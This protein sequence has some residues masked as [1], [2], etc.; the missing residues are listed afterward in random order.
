MRADEIMTRD[1][2]VVTPDEPIYRAAAIMRD[3]DVGMVP[4]VKERTSR[5]LE[6]IITDRDIAV[7][8]VAHQHDA[9]CRVRDH[10]T[11]NHLD[12]VHPDTDLDEVLRLMENDRVRRIIV[13][14]ARNRV[15]GVIAQADLALKL[16]P[17][18]PLLVEGLLE[19]VSMPIHA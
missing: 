6:G 19:R 5:K 2:V 11:A 1:P 12:T 7:R 13:V 8:C 15:V 16:G 14:D 10:M 3:R 17:R 18:R 4:V 9:S